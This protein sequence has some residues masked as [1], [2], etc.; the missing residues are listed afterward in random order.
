MQ[1]CHDT[2]RGVDTHVGHHELRFEL[3]QDLLVDLATRREIREIVCEPAV[4]FVQPGSQATDKSLLLSG[5]RIFI[6]AKHNYFLRDN[7]CNIQR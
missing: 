1:A 5:C 6:P 7:S 4:T 3:F 2:F